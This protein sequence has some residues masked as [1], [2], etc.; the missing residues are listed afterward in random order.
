MVNDLKKWDCVV[1][2]S[3]RNSD[4][5]FVTKKT[6]ISK[7]LSFN[8]WHIPNLLTRQVKSDNEFFTKLYKVMSQVRI[9]GEIEDEISIK[10]KRYLI[11]SR[12]LSRKNPNTCITLIKKDES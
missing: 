5:S 2:T 9:T 7:G 4:K 6:E 8:N 1:F 12:L 11:Q 3:F 10:K